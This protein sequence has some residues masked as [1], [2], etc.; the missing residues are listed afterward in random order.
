MKTINRKPQYLTNSFKTEEEFHLWLEEITSKKIL[1]KDLGQD[2][3][4]IW[5]AQSGEI[6]HCDF[7]ASIYNGKFINMQELSEFCPL[8]ILE[9][10]KWVRKMG[11]LVDEIKSNTK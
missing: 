10:N 2:M 9:D 7:H 5:V 4:M 11:L 6:I 1:L 8:E 3:Q